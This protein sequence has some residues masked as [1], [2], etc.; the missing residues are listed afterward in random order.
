[1]TRAS[2]SAPSSALFQHAIVALS[3]VLRLTHPADAMLSRYFREHKQLGHRDRG[4]IAEAVFAVLRHK[5]SLDALV[6][7]QVN[8]RRLL[9]AHLA[10]HQDLD[11]KALEPLLRG[12]EAELVEHL[13]QRRDAIARRV[14]AWTRRVSLPAS[15]WICRTGSTSACWPST[16]P[17]NCRPW[18]PPSTARRPWI[19]G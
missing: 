8:A 19:C 4:F 7:P 3:E 13:R 12:G 18:S 15:P 5:R 16:G 10:C 14:T 9:L 17:R 11:A 6:L 1:M 2:S